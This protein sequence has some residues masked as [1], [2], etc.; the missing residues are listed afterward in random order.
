MGKGPHGTLQKHLF[1]G[2]PSP[3]SAKISTLAL[4]VKFHYAFSLVRAVLCIVKDT[5]GHLDGFSLAAHRGYPTKF[6]GR[7]WVAQ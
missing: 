4:Q 5:L 6:V 3:E 2:S 1:L 7:P